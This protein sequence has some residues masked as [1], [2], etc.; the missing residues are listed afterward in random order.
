MFVNSRFSHISLVLEIFFRTQPKQV[1]KKTL[2]M[3]SKTNSSNS[4][5]AKMNQG[6]V[7][8][9]E[10]LLQ[11]TET[12]TN[13]KQAFLKPT[14]AYDNSKSFIGKNVKFSDFDSVK[15]FGNTILKPTIFRTKKSYLIIEL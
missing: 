2:D 4:E 6:W 9:N 12:F 5:C 8:A 14:Y 3:K 1:M 11:S 10:S 7:Q 13:S 15:L